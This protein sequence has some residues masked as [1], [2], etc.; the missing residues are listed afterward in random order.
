M[1]RGGSTLSLAEARLRRSV[2]S[3]VSVAIVTGGGSGIGRATCLELARRGLA[4]AVADLAS[5]RAEAVAAEARALGAQAL[6]LPVNV[7]SSEG[8]RRSVAA[9]G[10][11][12]GRVDVL[13]NGAG[14]YQTG[15][16]GEISEEDWERVLAVNLKGAF[17]FCKEVVPWMQRR[18]SGA[19]VNVS[20][21]SG[22]TKSLL[23]GANYVASKAGIIGLTMC[24]ASQLAADG[25]R[26][27]C[28]A[29]GSIDTPMVADLTPAERVAL[30]ERSPLGRLGEPEEVAA[31]IAFLVSPAA[32]YITGETLNVNGGAFMV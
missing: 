3:A 2:S 8:V 25:I 22:R 12:F 31:A 13:V 19:I 6:P 1:D 17:L 14:I 21:V 23:A 20:S 7:A 27:N 16:I 24:L 18:R 9:V 4:V 15:K 30:A 5:E 29:P 32:S 26:V 10:E 28:V 11:R